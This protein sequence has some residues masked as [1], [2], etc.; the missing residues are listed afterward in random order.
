MICCWLIEVEGYC[1]E[2]A[3][4]AFKIARPNGIRHVGSTLLLVVADFEILFRLC[5][6]DILDYKLRLEV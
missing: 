6:G 2:E 5:M 1:V 4:E 3:L